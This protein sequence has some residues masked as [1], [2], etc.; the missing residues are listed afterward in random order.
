MPLKYPGVLGVSPDLLASIA[1][2]G[3]GDI[4]MFDGGSPDILY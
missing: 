3:C 1:D 4:N 2:L